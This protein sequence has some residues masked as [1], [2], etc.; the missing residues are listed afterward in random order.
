MERYAE[1]KEMLHAE[2]DRIQKKGELSAASL[3][4]A[5]AIAHTLKDV[6]TI[7]AMEGESGYSEHYPPYY[8]GGVYGYDD[9]GSYGPSRGRGSNA[10]RD[11]MGRYSS[12]S[13]RG[14]YDDGRSYDD[15]DG[16]GSYRGR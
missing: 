12:E 1:L 10:R 15:G 13:R 6:V 5:D 8:R 3:A 11:T 4:Q 7:E 16:M 2:L 14:Y 9:G